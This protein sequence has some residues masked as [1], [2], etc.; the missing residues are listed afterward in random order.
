MNAEEFLEH[1]DIRNDTIYSRNEEAHLLSH[2]LEAFANYKTEQLQ[3]E[4]ERLKGG[5]KER[6]DKFNQAMKDHLKERDSV[7][8]TKEQPTQVHQPNWEMKGAD[9]KCED[10]E[11]V[12]ICM[13]CD[14]E[15]EN[16]DEFCK[17]CGFKQ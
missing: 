2:L 9:V 1:Y 6:L 11:I 12:S 4:V 5:N 13:S 17:Y 16:D 3:K 7:Q 15:I 14:S 8:P 10:Y